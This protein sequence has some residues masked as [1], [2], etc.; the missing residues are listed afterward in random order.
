[1]R[2]SRR[3]LGAGGVTPSTSSHG[4]GP[5]AAFLFST[6]S[7]ASTAGAASTPK[8]CCGGGTPAPGTASGAPTPDSTGGTSAS[9]A[10]PTQTP[11]VSG[12]TH[13]RNQRR[14]RRRAR[15]GCVRVRVGGFWWRGRGPTAPAPPRPSASALPPRRPWPSPPGHRAP[16]RSALPPRSAAWSQNRTANRVGSQWRRVSVPNCGLR[17]R[18]AAAA[19]VARRLD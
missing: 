7:V 11:R 3:I 15:A 13:H 19:A 10:N 9:C 8:A 14:R 17:M 6:G 16:G 1:M 4:C 12:P 5:S 2:T 18:D